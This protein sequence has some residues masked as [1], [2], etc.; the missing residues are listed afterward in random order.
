MCLASLL[1]YSPAAL[2]RIKNL[3]AGRDAYYLPGVMHKDDVAVADALG[4]P[5]LGCEPEIC[6]LYSSKSGSRRV[7]AAAGVSAPPGE[8]DV[9]SAQQL[10]ESLAR[11]ICDQPHVRRWLLKADVGFQGRYIAYLDVDK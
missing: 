8:H 11:L 4:I 10:H 2:N 7:F 1:K 3:I 5:V 9:Y 6:H